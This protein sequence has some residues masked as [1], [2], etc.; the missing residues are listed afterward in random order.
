MKLLISILALCFLPLILGTHLKT[1]SKKGAWSWGGPKTKCCVTVYENCNFQGASKEFC[2][3]VSNLA[4]H[5]WNDRIS[6]WKSNCN[7]SFYDNTKSGGATISGKSN[8]DLTK[9]C[10]EYGR[11]GFLG[12][13]KVCKRNWNDEISSLIIE[14]K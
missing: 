14:K 10:I 7:P 13:Q 5:G 6:S 9:E 8:A 11:G 3:S 2:Q 12:L 1:N 4:D